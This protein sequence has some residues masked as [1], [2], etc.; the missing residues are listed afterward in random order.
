MASQVYAFAGCRGRSYL[1]FSLLLP[2]LCLCQVSIHWTWGEGRVTQPD[3]NRERLLFPLLLVLH[4]LL[5]LLSWSQVCWSERGAL[6]SASR[7]FLFLF[8]VCIFLRLTILMTQVTADAF[9]PSPSFLL[10]S[11][12]D[13]VDW[14]FGVEREGRNK[15]KNK[16]SHEA[17]CYTK[18]S[19]ICIYR[20][21]LCHRKKELSLSSY[22]TSGI[23][24]QYF[25]LFL[26]H[27]LALCHSNEAIAGEVT[28]SA[29]VV[30]VLLVVAVSA[31]WWPDFHL[32]RRHH[33]YYAVE[34]VA[35]AIFLH[36]ISY[37]CV[38]VR[39]RERERKNASWREKERKEWAV[40]KEQMCEG[41]WKK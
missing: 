20:F 18:S 2:L 9:S 29:V 7:I 14:S 35:Q 40:R 5:L 13:R 28:L 23:S 3:C 12:A 26:S 41:G 34:A 8:A 25:L 27:L 11:P 30:T 16:I 31:I 1:L 37:F 32:V 22:L 39:E 36:Y 10:P 24:F 15:R 6:A 17:T 19:F 21:Y 38:C 33:S 4:L